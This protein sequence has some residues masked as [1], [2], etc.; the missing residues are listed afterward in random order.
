MRRALPAL[1]LLL[2]AA[3]PL[4]RA[5]L[6]GGGSTAVSVRMELQDPGLPLIPQRPYSLTL[7]IRYTHGPGAFVTPDPAETPPGGR[8]C[9]TLSVPTPPPWATV[10]L[11]PEEVCF[12]IRTST[13]SAT[14]EVG[15]Q[16][17]VEINVTQDAP[18]L[19]PY[20]FTVVFDAPAT[21]TLAAARG[22]VSR[23]IMPGFV[24]TLEL[25]VPEQVAVR[26]GA[27]QQV[28]VT[29]RNLG[30]GPIAVQFQ[31]ATAP[32]GVR[33]VLPAP[34]TIP[35]NGTQ[36]V[37]VLVQA[38]WTTPV[39]GSIG[40]DG[41]SHHPARPDLPGDSP[42]ARLDVDGKAAV[43]GAEAPLLALALL[44]LAVLRRR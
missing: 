31:N 22:E 9:G 18:A 35:Q 39:R 21:G 4:A 19:E 38:P 29:V 15:N 43:P 17:I 42:R 8:V 30:N 7:N 23:T 2:L 36:V 33:V 28:P 32:Q 26:G 41:Q 3:A 27:P 14:N 13:A 44:G 12:V 5:Q 24:G 6:P 37:H 40:F 11:I 20:N 1:L 10:R 34:V 16:S 25:D